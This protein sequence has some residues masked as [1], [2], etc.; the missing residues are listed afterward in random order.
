MGITADD[1]ASGKLKVRNKYQF[2]NLDRFNITWTVTEDGTVIDRG[3][4]PRLKL[5]PLS[6]SSLTVPFKKISPL[7]AGADY[8]LRVA[9]TLSKDELW[10]KAGEEVAAAQFVLPVSTQTD[11][12]CKQPLLN[13]RSMCNRTTS[14]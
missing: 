6:D 14:K 9:F 7:V 10:A 2:I 12:H 11:N 4:L 13:L 5:A 1:L 3:T 8:H